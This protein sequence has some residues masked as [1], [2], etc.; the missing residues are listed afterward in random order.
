MMSP[1]KEDGASVETSAD[2][3]NPR[4]IQGI[5]ALVVTGGFIGTAIVA[6]FVALWRG[7]VQDG[8]SV[9]NII[10]APASL[11]IGFFFGKKAAE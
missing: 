8:V 2:I 10:A 3:G 5:L 1:S 7:T 9:L 4:D 11:I 6:T